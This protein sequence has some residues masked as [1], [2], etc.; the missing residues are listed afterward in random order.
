MEIKKIKKSKWVVLKD[1]QEVFTAKT[2]KAC[3]QFIDEQ[4]P[5]IDEQAPKKKPR[6]K[7]P[8]ITGT[9]TLLVDQNPKRKGCACYE[10]FNLYK[11]GMTTEEYIQAGGKRDDIRW[12]IAHGF[13][14][15]N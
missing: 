12:D 6:K 5:N 4:A 15:V 11:D 3:A 2:R 10:R 14:Q 7:T 13:I 8:K 1:D 9:I